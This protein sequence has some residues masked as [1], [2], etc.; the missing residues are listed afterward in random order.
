MASYEEVFK[1][2]E[3]STRGS[4]GT[5]AFRD[6]R[7][8]IDDVDDD[9]VETLKE[10]GVTQGTF[11]PWPKYFAIAEDAQ[12]V[13]RMTRLN[14]LVRVNYGRPLSFI[15]IQSS[16]PDWQVQFRG[17]S[18]PERILRE[19]P[20][21]N[22]SERKPIGPNIF[23]ESDEGTFF[24]NTSTGF[25]QLQRSEGRKL[26]GFDIEVPMTA[27]ILR[28]QITKLDF[29]TGV[30]L[31]FYAKKCNSVLWH[32][33]PGRYAYFDDLIIDERFGVPATTQV[34]SN[35]ESV[36]YDIQLSILIRP[37]PWTPQEMVTTW[38]DP[39]TGEEVAVEGGGISGPRVERFRRYEEVDFHEIFNILER[40]APATRPGRIGR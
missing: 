4:S 20:G 38:T 30:S 10:L 37:T 39:A 14:W 18:F 2:R 3:G 19:P 33:I 40:L 1:S 7:V 31:A 9:P 35:Q 17:V 24:A 25:H 32:G 5:R 8:T 12:P 29:R 21:Q 22:T 27:L 16:F 13:E 26:V 28:R 23:T 36:F 6:L 34:P 15:P 11:H